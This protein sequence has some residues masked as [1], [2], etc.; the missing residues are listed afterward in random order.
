MKNI[1]KAFII[2]AASIGLSTSLFA[3]DQYLTADAMV[4]VETGKL[5]RDPALIISN[6]KI[7]KI[8]KQGSFP[9]PKGAEEITLNGHTIMPGLMD[10]HVH[11][12]GDA[13]TPFFVE[14]GYSIPRQTVVAVKNAEKTLMAGYTTV[15][16]VGASGYSVIGVRDG[17][18][19]GDIVGP[20]IYAS[21]PALS[22]TGGHCDNNFLAP[23]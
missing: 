14:M 7:I 1:T 8:G 13:T 6:G 5:M 22:I 18:N 21:G 20:R 4:D 19:D 3:T 2:S 12:S 11:L 15:R 16:N 10:M 23:E 17:I 9:K